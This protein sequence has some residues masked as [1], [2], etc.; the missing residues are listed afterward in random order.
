M[1]ATSSGKGTLFRVFKLPE[2]VQLYTFKWG[3]SH[4]IIYSLTFGADKLLC[5]SD[6]GTLHVFNLDKYSSS[7]SVLGTESIPSTLATSEG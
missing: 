1:L 5:S 4:A 3:I 6:S 2:G 7:S